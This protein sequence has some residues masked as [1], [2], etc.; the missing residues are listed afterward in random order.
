MGII[1]GINAGSIHYLHPLRDMKVGIAKLYTGHCSP[2]PAIALNQVIVVGS[3]IFAG[4]SLAE[5]HPGIVLSLINPYQIG[6]GRYRAGRQYIISQKGIYKPGFSGGKMAGKGNTVFLVPKLL[7]QMT[8]MVHI[9]A[10][11]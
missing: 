11:I 9:A 4:I 3:Q 5:K 10:M 6:R 7:G 2:I 1:S 8:D